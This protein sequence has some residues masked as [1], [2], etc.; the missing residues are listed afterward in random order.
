MERIQ[1]AQDQKTASEDSSPLQE[2]LQKNVSLVDLPGPK[3]TRLVVVCEMCGKTAEKCFFLR[4]SPRTF[5]LSLL[6]EVPESEAE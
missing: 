2:L 1:Q 6:V 3:R 4:I 5:G